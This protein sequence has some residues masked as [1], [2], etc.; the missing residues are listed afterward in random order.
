M[1]DLRAFAEA[2]GLAGVAV[3]SIGTVIGGV[4]V[5]R[6]LDP[7]GREIALRHRHSHF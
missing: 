3:T 2:A 4:A 7:Q 5:P 1:S 6:F